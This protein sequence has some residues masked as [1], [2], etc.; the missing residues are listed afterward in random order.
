M[1]VT[2][3]KEKF[4]TDLKDL[5]PA[6][7]IMNFF[8][9]LCEAYL[10]KNR[11]D[12]ALEPQLEPT[13]EVLSEFFS[14]LVRLQ[15]ECPIQYIL[16]KTEFMDTHFEVDENV[17]IPRPETEELIQWILDSYPKDAALRILDIGTG[18]GCIPVVLAKHLTISN[19]EGMDLSGKALKIARKNARNN[20]VRVHFF[21]ADIL[22]IS[23]LHDSYDVIVSNPPYV[24]ESE[25]LSMRNNV[26]K[27]EP[28]LALFVSD[29]DPLIF[30]RRIAIL[31]KSS[32]KTGGSLFFE[33]NQYLARDL[34]QLLENEG[35]ANLQVK[36][37]I[38][39][40]DRMIRAVK[41]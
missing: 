35:Y 25:K 39:G 37:D 15:E 1:T 33:I 27:Y 14:A 31:G 18:S 9:L 29:G 5:Y 12:L 22:N 11:L 4:L 16:G 21:Q 6:E 34:L 24:R 8:Y 2:L 17:L 36:K 41:K 32:L 40:A 30:Y 23:R 13:H 28:D 19:I 26:L 3:L 38:Y 7:E 10:D 20:K